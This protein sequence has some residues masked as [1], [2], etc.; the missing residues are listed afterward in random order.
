MERVQAPRPTSDLLST[1]SQLSPKQVEVFRE[2]QQRPDGAQVAQLAEA[3][4][5]HANTVRGHLDE[6]MSA[7]VVDR[8][9]APSPGRGR[10]SHIY[11]ARVPRTDKASRAFIGLIEVFADTL[12][13]GDTTAAKAM[14]RKWAAKVNAKHHTNLRMDLDTA[15]QCTAQVLR[16]MGFDPVQR[17]DTSVGSVRELG[18]NACPFITAQGER[19]EPVICAMH[20]GFL[21][22]GIGDVQVELRPHD[23]PGQCGARL[24]KRG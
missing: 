8:R 6:L 17:P 11:T 5:M 15:E 9:V 10:P 1:L 19:P 23:R 21:D 7:G 3:L 13:G 24:T 12:D 20:E 16:E 4:G 14:G 2:L 22:E 18:L